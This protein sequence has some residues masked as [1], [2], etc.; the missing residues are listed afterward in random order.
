MNWKLI[1]GEYEIGNKKSSV[2]VLTLLDNFSFDKNKVAIY[3]KVMTENL[4]VTRIL[5]NILSNKNI[6]YLVV[7]G[8]DVNG[9]YPGD[10]LISFYNQG[11]TE[12]KKTNIITI[13]N[14]RA[15]DPKLP[16]EEIGKVRERFRNQI[17][18]VNMLG[19]KDIKKIK[20]KIEKLLE[21]NSSPMSC[22]YKVK[23]KKAE[24]L[25]IFIQDNIAIHSKINLNNFYIMRR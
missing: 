13:K 3:G 7:C 16:I 8:R 2:A 25:G 24:N 19:E 17:T 20:S 6:R 10:A 12:D 23:L 9:H 11:Y 21:K 22:P 15:K 14:T 4:G 18:L 5:A 1:P